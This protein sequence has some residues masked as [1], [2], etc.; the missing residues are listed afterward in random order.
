MFGHAQIYVLSTPRF[1]I[2]DLG[3]GLLDTQNLPYMYDQ[4][5]KG[6]ESIGSFAFSG[7]KFSL[8][9]IT[10]LIR[11]PRYQSVL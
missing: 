9:L 11:H 2:Q 5:V 10:E 6:G 8:F 3:C 1:Y 7:A 4:L